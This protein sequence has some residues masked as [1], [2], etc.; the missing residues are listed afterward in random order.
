M[1][2]APGP[3]LK[4]W[5]PPLLADAGISDKSMLPATASAAE[6]LTGR[7]SDTKAIVALWLLADEK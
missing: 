2:A 5:K 1:S 3:A 7:K 4:L 6:R